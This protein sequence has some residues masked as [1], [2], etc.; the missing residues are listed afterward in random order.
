MKTTT[1][2]EATEPANCDA[3]HTTGGPMEAA[4]LAG[5]QVWMCVYPTPCLQRARLARLGMWAA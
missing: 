5:N 1:P 2:A 3:C 4:T